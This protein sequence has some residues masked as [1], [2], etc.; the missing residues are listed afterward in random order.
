[1]PA[2]LE[3][4]EAVRQGLPASLS[5]DRGE[6]RL[7]PFR[8]RVTKI[9]REHES[10]APTETIPPARTASL[11]L[12]RRRRVRSLTSGA[13]LLIGATCIAYFWIK[14]AGRAAAPAVSPAAYKSLAVLPLRNLTAN[15]AE[16]VHLADGIAQSLTTKLTQLSGLRVTPWVTARRYRDSDSSVDAIAGVLSV[17]AVLVGTLQKA[18]ERLRGTVAL[19]D[20]KSGL[21]MWED[22]FDEPLADVFSVQNRIA[23]GVATR[24]LGKLSGQE[25]DTL[26]TPAGR[27][28]AAYENYLKGVAAMQREGPAASDEALALFLKAVDA[29]PGLALA[30]AALGTVRVDRYYFAWGG[31]KEL[32]S[33]EAD[34]RRAL[35]IDPH[36]IAARRGL[37]RAFWLRGK[38]EETLKQGKLVA[39]SGA[40]DVEALMARAEAYLFGGLEHKSLALFEE[41]LRQHPAN[42]GSLWLTTVAGVWSG[43][44]AESIRAGER[45]LAG[46]GEDPEVLLWMGLAWFSLGDTTRAEGFVERAILR[47]WPHR[48]YWGALYGLLGDIQKK[49]ETKRNGNAGST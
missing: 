11:R 35:Q 30:H 23:V 45:Y 34:L 25:A 33:G 41:V 43:R 12:A 18:G 17:E 24:L 4:L 6:A 19:V 26:A 44:F 10:L 13:V 22:D 2:F 36:L 14:H 32:V 37:I 42:A 28:P 31:M 9:A 46:F 48:S 3:A 15:P 1:M 20:G 40:T 49:A 27:D 16:S 38:S 39:E 29:D 47:P 8:R 7:S 5:S 21:R